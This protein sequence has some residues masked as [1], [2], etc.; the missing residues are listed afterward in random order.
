MNWHLA[1]KQGATN[2][3]GISDKIVAKSGLTAP[4]G[5]SDKGCDCNFCRSFTG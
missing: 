3:A 1:T 5:T 2:G 4:E